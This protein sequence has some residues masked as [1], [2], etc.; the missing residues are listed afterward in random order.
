M[1]DVAFAQF[2]HKQSWETAMPGTK[3]STELN[4]E[5]RAAS[6]RLKKKKGAVLLRAGT[7]PRGAFL[8]RTGRVKLQLEGAAALYPPRV[9][10]P[11]SIVGFP[12]SVSG[13]P[14]S[15]TV[16]VL[17]DCEL[18]FISRKEL[19]ALLRRNTNAALQI[20]QILS[21]EIY[22]MRNTAQAGMPGSGET[23]H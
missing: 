2:N 8:V 1:A 5:L 21:E 12:A 23:I 16:E 18:D 10:G 19:L 7:R 22:I 6:K 3:I 20:L 15:L 13:E 4:K 14:Y 11:G 9:L 17:Q